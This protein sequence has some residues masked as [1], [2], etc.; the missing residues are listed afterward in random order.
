MSDTTFCNCE[1]CQKNRK[2]LEE[3]ANYDSDEYITYDVEDDRGLYDYHLKVKK[4]EYT[5]YVKDENRLRTFRKEKSWRDFTGDVLKYLL[6]ANQVKDVREN[7][8]KIMKDAAMKDI[9]KNS[10]KE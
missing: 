10:E 1:L 9:R 8:K 6:V 3:E 5:L 7:F 2:K 4:G